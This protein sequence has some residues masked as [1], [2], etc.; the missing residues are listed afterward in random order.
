MAE[1]K[2]G[3]IK[4]VYQGTW[5]TGR[6]YVVDDVVTNGGKT[7]ICVIS[8]TS[9]S[10]FVSDLNANPQLT[11]WN[12]VADGT[13]WRNTWAATTYYNLGDM[14]L[15]GGIVY[16]CKT[17]HTSATNVSPTYLG[18]ENDQSKWDAFATSFNWSGAWTNTTR[19][20]VRDLVYYGGSTY[21]CNTAHISATTDASGLEADIGKWDTF[22]QGITYLGDWS[23]SSVRYKQNDVV[24]FGADLWI[25]TTYH[26]SSGTTIDTNNFSIFVNGFQFEGSWTSSGSYQVGD[27]VTYGGYTYTAIQN[28]TSSSPKT[29]STQT[30][31][32]KVFTSGLNYSGEWDTGTSYKIGNVVTVGGYTYIATADNSASKPPSAN[33]GQLSSGIRWATAANT[34]Y[35]NVASSNVSATGSGSP[36]FTVTRTGTAYSVVIGGTAGTGYTVNDT[37]KVLG[38]ALGGSTPG[39]DL[40]VKVATI[41]GGGGTGPIG[42]VTVSTGYAATWKTGITYVVGDAVYYGNSSYICISAHVGST[43]VNDPLSDTGTY[44]NI[45]SSGADSGALTTQGDMVYYGANG[46]QRLPVGT[47]GQVLRVNGNKPEWQYYGQLQNIVYVAPNGSDT[48]GNGQGITLDKPWASLLYACRQVE[49]GYLNV[50]AG[51]ALKVNKQFMM[52]EVNNFI[53]V[54]YSFNVT[55]TSASGNTFVVGGSS[56]SSQVT[57]ANMYY[58]MPITF[59][60]ATGGVTAGT[61]YYVNTIPTS[62]TFTVSEAYQS[63]LTRAITPSNNTTSKAAFN[64]TQSKAERDTGTVIDGII[65]DLTHGGNLYS[66]TATKAYFKTLT[67]FTS[68]GTTQQAP[69]FAGSLAYLKDTLFPAVMANT[70]PAANYQTL[71]GIST[72]AIQNTVTVTTSLVE[73]GALTTAQGLLS[74]ITSAI[75][76]G[77]YSQIPQEAR[78]HTTVYLKTGTYNEYGPIVIPVDTAI[79]GDEL[80]STIVQVAK[81]QTYLGNDR[82]KTSAALLRIQSVVADLVANNTITPTT[83]GTTFPNTQTQIKTLPAGDT[84][85]AS[86]V[87]LVVTNTRAIQDMFAGGGVITG[88][89]NTNYPNGLVHQ[90]AISMPTVTGYNSSYLANYGD[91]LALIQANYQFIKDELVSF[92]NTDSNLTGSAQWSAYSTTYQAETKRDIGYIL[93]AICYDLTYGCNSQSVI[94]GSSYYSLNTAQLVAP[95][96]LGVTESLARLSVI[97][98]QIV[99]KT[100]VSRSTGNTTTQYTTG[101]AGSAA[102]AVFAQARVADILYWINNGT[103]DTTA[104]TFT[105]TTS[106]TTLTVSSVTGTIK[107]GQLVTGGTIAA[108]TYITAGSGTSW[109]ISV[110]QTATATGSTMAITPIA[111]GAYALAS[112]ANKASYDA[113]Q[114]RASEVANDAQA[115]VTRFYQ[116][117]SPILSLTNR[118]AGYVVSALAYDVLFGGNFQS[119]QCG[120]SYNRPITSVVNLQTTLADSTYG[121]LGFIGERVKLLAAN[122]SVVQ[123]NAVI[124]EMVA[125][126]YGQP[127]TTATF[128]GTITGTQLVVNGSVTGTIAIGM[129]LSGTGIAA[130]TSIVSGSGTT[131]LLNYN[132][133]A[134]STTTSITR[135]TTSV[136]LNGVTYNNVLTAGTTSGFVPGLVITITGATIG[137][138]TAGTY[139][140]KQVLSSTQFTVSQLYLGTVFAITSTASGSMTGVVY[141]IYGELGLTTDIT[142]SGTT[143]PVSAV[144]TSTNLIT[145]SSNAGMLVNMPIVFTGLPAN[146]TTTA[147]TISSSSITLG[148]TVSSLGV[149]VGQK[150]WFSGFTP[151]AS[152][153]NSS[154]VA[155]QVY[156]VKTAS[157][158]AITISATFGGSAL[159]L[160][161]ATGLTLTATFNAAGGLVAGNIYWI[162]S[163]TAGTYPAAGTT[164]TVTNGYKSGTAFTITNTV[165]GLSATATAGMPTNQG[166]NDKNTNGTIQPWNNPTGSYSRASGYNNTLATIQGAEIIRANKA[167]LANEAVAYVLSQYTGTVTTTA[168]NGTVTCSGAHNLTVGDPVVFSGTMFDGNIVA[169]TVYWVLTTPTTSTLTLTITAPGTGTQSTKT[170]NGGT[171]SMTVSYYIRTAQAVR[172]A[173]YHIEGLIYDLG[174]TGNYKSTR[175]AQVY[176]SAQGGATANDLFHAR[177]GT[178]LRNMTLNGL[179][180]AMTLPNALGTKRPTA[181]SYTSLD[182]GFGPNDSGAWISTRSPYPQNLTLFGSGCTGLKID[183]ALH[184]GG[185][186][187]IVANDYTTIISDGIGVWCTGSNALTELVSV[188]AYYSYAGYLAEYGGRIR[189]T[190]GNSSYGTYGVI[191]EGIDSYETPIYGR[192]NNRANPAYI[193]NVVTDGVDKVLRLEFENAGSAYTNALPTVSG[194]GY[195]IV[196]IQD[197]FRDSAVFET[198]LVDLNNGQGVGGSNY[199]TAANVAQTGAVGSVTIANSDIQLSTAYVGMRIQLTAGTGVGQYANIIGYSQGSKLA[200]VIRPSFATLTVTTNSTTVFTVASTAT[201]Y[202]GQPVYLGAAIGGLSTLT[203]YYAIVANGTTFKLATS[204]ANAASGTGI[205]LTATSATPAV[206]TSS[207]IVGYTLTVGTLS[208]GTIYPGMLLTGGALLPNTYVVS[209]SG[210]TW[211]VSVSQNLASTTITGTISVPVYEAGWDHVVPGNT[212]QTILDATSGYIIEPAI[213]YTAPGFTSQS[214]TMTAAATTTWAGLAYGQGKFVATS[215]ATGVASTATTADG[216]TWAAGG[217]LPTD[218][219]AKWGTIVYGGGQN[220]TAT[221]TVGGVGGSGAQ[222]TAVIGTGNTAGQIISINV[223]NGGYNYLTPPTIVITDATGAGATATARV[224]NGSIQAVDMVITGSLYANPTITVVTSSLSSISA[225]TWGS[226]YYTAPQV[227]I[228]APFTATGWSNGGAATSG[229]YYS[230]VDTTVSPNVTN[231]YLAGGTGT[232]SATKPTFTNAVYGKSGYGASGVG[233]SGTYGVTLT[234]VGT[235]A[236]ASANTNTNTAGYGVTSYTISQTGYGYASTPTITV[237]DLNAAFMAVSTATNSAAYSIDQG[238]SWSATAGT[239][240]KTNLNMLAYGNNLYIAVGGTSSAVGVSY[241]PGNSSSLGTTTWSD[242]SSNMITNSSGYSAIAYGAGVFCAI[243]GTV[244]AFTAADPTRWYAGAT[245]ASKTWVDIAYGNGR[246]VA[247]ASDGT[248]QYTTNWQTNYWTTTPSNAANNTWTTVLNNPVNANGV[249]TWKNISYG[250]GLFVAVATSS[251]AVATSPDGVN[252]TYYA[253]GMPSS[254]NWTGLAF[255]NPVNATLGRVPTWVSVSNTSGKIAA[256]ISTGATPQGRIKVVNNQVSEV[257]MIEP[258]SGFPRGNVTATSTTSTGTITVDDITNLTANQPIVFNGTSSG[259]IVAGTY[260]YVKGTPT[261]TSGLAGTIQISTTAGGSVFA[262]T[263]STPSGMTYFAS[264]IITQT[265]PNKV[266]TAPLAARIGNG[267]LGN[268]SFG[269]RGTA[270]TTAT[271]SYAG[272]G[273]ADL[274]QVGT[275]VNVSGLFQIPTAGCNVVF[276]SITGTSRWYKLVSVTN[277]LGVAGN[278]SATFQI[279]PGISTLLAPAHNDLITTNLQYSN[280]RLTG[281]DFLYIGTGGFSA[282]NYPYVDATRAVMSNQELFVGGGRVFF[283]STDQDGNFNVGNLFGVQQSTGTATLNAS[284]FNLSGLQSLTLG[285]V[286]L[287]VGSAT[288]YQFST[289]PYF[290]ANSD[291]VVPTQKA[292]KAFIT[293]QI[294]GGQS[295]LNVNTITSGQIYIA[296]NTISNTNNAQIYVS[297]KMTFTGGIDGAPVALAYFGQR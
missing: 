136:V 238:A 100:A 161:D 62:T 47:D 165:T 138:L 81:P 76:A 241:A 89:T 23:G 296:G 195:N 56:T 129:Q 203:V 210:S 97:L 41:T 121:A 20:K 57:T 99:Q 113:I 25:C 135:V 48:S 227:V 105:G 130:G 43:G 259:G 229:A 246:F 44:W 230:A 263:A 272:D 188:F 183:A 264:P 87:N 202:T 287:G 51:L 170:L 179:T 118:D 67:S 91:G 4:F 93:D 190:N 109:T 221:A 49:E 92:L 64:Y 162:N 242:Q 191:A 174:L 178:G 248:L 198:R 152:G 112:T 211:T 33:W 169:G 8:H 223:V 156:Y 35:T 28:S 128:N 249:T 111:S 208:S 288:I 204:A 257:R 126:I 146:I 84:G 217:A 181:G 108:G 278:Y 124:D 46:P 201:M 94:T 173:T 186:K 206:M 194:A 5:T 155:N 73:S 10:T 69:V 80:R 34:T 83:T 224:L 147:T 131:W 37:L 250:Q 119:I 110:S 38:S 266:N 55:G 16:V 267:A 12:L 120:R 258:G 213:S 274:Y 65:F 163:V 237:T 68:T 160:T 295:S 270:N 103:A 159:V 116:N 247:L 45:L 32:W 36:T 216:I 171:G 98:G 114:A 79:V 283:T 39:N 24:K 140:I 234:Y 185:N 18:L 82:P 134:A 182:A 70:A 166:I 115:W 104:A 3:R 281:H 199:L 63:G 205:T 255:G 27:V 85:N 137:N 261:S 125:Q 132:Q 262:L 184:N 269:H 123:T 77:T 141:G 40:V 172:D 239:T 158:S 297:S 122:G 144:T 1:F 219:S 22:N 58:G 220:A 7:Y 61:V 66:S 127:T 88:P 244:S 168:T 139:Y 207:I 232:F 53:Q 226:G 197:E 86:A 150:V 193:T 101:T 133:S 196:T 268:P 176:L 289:D 276:S 175:S 286:S 192:L 19:Y 78:P 277:V 212:I 145:V 214:I 180:G 71:N 11:K 6:G 154:I 42:T 225:T 215:N 251:Q 148:A 271:A 151:Q 231:Y 106:G 245:L 149:A 31:Y 60:A 275:Y 21:V 26:T 107:I 233:A 285:S 13:T 157:A 14:V 2:L 167:F 279:N 102:A 222:L 284:A 260:Y 54:N 75:T 90:P 273:Y 218:A 280:V 9:A 95:Y 293:A 292:I 209:G 153:T 189:A 72:K 291:G 15:Y 253:T 52:K 252:W 235:L 30:A 74:I 50:N 290:T 265:D 200:N 17:A 228:A 256:R 164:I 117:E 294:G 142:A 96:L 187:S 29:P 282:T 177:N 243:G 254:S 59:T 236:V 143:I 240:G